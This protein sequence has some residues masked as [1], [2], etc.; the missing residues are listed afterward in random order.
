MS[1][2]KELAVCIVSI[3]TLSLA[4]V[5]SLF[6]C[7]ISFSSLC[8]AQKTRPRVAWWLRCPRHVAAFAVTPPYDGHSPKLM[9]KYRPHLLTVRCLSPVLHQSFHRLFRR[10]PSNTIPPI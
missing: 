1:M 4:A 5:A 3:D 7:V 9:N 8:G 6:V 2:Q 10:L